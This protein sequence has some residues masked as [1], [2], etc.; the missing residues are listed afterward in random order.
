E[1]RGGDLA[2]KGIFQTFRQQALHAGEDDEPALEAASPHPGVEIGAQRFTILPPK[3]GGD[4]VAFAGQYGLPAMR[5]R[6]TVAD[7]QDV[8]L[9]DRAALE[10]VG[11]HGGRWPAP[12]ELSVRNMPE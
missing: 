2:F 10:Q 11:G 8:G 6:E 12:A 7:D 5:H 1:W 4:T 9:L 3:G